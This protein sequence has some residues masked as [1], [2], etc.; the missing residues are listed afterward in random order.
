[1][2]TFSLFSVSTWPRPTVAIVVAKTATRA[3][4]SA[5][6]QVET[7]LGAMVSAFAVMTKHVGFL[8]RR[9]ISDHVL[10]LS[11]IDFGGLLT[12]LIL[13]CDCDESIRV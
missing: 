5:A 10:T 9:A 2:F 8:S 4:F 7:L 3:A 12:R 6:V 11:M 13:V 1:L